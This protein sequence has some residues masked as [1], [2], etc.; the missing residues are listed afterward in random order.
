MMKYRPQSNLPLD[1]ASII[2]LLNLVTLAKEDL[3]TEI[4]YSFTRSHLK[5]GYL[6]LLN[7]LIYQMID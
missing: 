2:V 6:S 4:S 7:I 1:F 3:S 5:E